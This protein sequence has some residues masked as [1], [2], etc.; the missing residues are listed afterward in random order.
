[1]LVLTRKPGQSIKIGDDITL[2]ITRVRGNTIQI[3]IDA[4]REIPVL[5]NEISKRKSNSIGNLSPTSAPQ[6]HL[7]TSG[8]ELPDL[9]PT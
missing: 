4:P 8:S 3:G 6:L 7:V 1:M 2:H 5:R 9:I